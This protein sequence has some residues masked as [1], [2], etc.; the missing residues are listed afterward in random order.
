ML[1][2]PEADEHDEDERRDAGRSRARAKPGSAQASVTQPP[3]VL[4]RA[5]R[6]VAER[7]LVLAARARLD[8]LDLAERRGA[9]SPAAQ[10]PRSWTSSSF[11]EIRIFSP[12]LPAE[13]RI[14]LAGHL[15]E[16]P[17]AARRQ[18][19]LDEIAEELDEDDLALEPSSGRSRA[20]R[21]RRPSTAA[22]RTATSAGSPTAGARRRRP[23]TL[24]PDVLVVLDDRAGRRPARSTLPRMMLLSPMNARDELGRRPASRSSAD[25]RSAGSAPSFMTTIRSAID[26]ASSWLCVTW[27][28]ISP[29]WR[30]RLRSSTRMRSWSSR[31]RSPSG[32]SSSSAFGFVTSTRASATRCCWPPESA[33]GLRSASS[34]RPTISSASIARFAPLVLA[35][36]RA[37]SARTRRSRARSGAGRAR[38]AGRR[39][40]SAACAAAARRATARRGRCRRSVGISWPPIMRSVVV[41]PQPDGP[42]STTYSPWST[43]RLTSSTA[44]RRRRGRPSSGRSR[45]SPDPLGCGGGGGSPPPPCSRSAIALRHPALG[46]EEVVPPLDLVRA[47][48]EVRVPRRVVCRRAG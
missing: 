6:A 41:L 33:R 30:C 28:N 29:S 4:L 47:V 22:A 14:A 21:A 3:S 46:A 13:R 35:D 7:P 18:V 45:S 25:R 39:S 20:T 16:H 38:S 42:S 40:S 10:A 17:L 19:E 1:R 43:C 5:A 24:D 44:T 32:S 27:M 8:L 37:S 2:R 31:S 23:T 15:R 26:S 12:S 9:A 34:A 36:A 11:Q 48:R